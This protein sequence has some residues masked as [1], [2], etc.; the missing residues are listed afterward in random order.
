MCVGF[1]Q[2]RSAEKG[3]PRCGKGGNL[4]GVKDLTESRHLPIL[5]VDKARAG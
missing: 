1:N 2:R 5:P 3:P 4:T